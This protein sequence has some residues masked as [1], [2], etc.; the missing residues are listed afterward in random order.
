MNKRAEEEFSPNILAY[1]LAVLII[2]TALII[3]YEK[4]CKEDLTCF[5]QAFSSCERAKVIA[6]ENDNTFEYKIIEKEKSDCKVEVTLTEVNPEI[7][8][9]IQEMFKDKSMTCTLPIEQEFTLDQLN[10]CQGPLKETIYELTIQ[11]MYNLLA[12]NLGDIISQMKK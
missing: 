3:N 8:P 4:D 11:K 12:Q 6:Y 1:G 9:S 10:L 5:N 7:E 2:I